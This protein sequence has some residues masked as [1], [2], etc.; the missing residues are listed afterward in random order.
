MRLRVLLLLVIN[1]VAIAALF[2]ML[3]MFGIV[4]YYSMVKD[5]FYQPK[6]RVDD[7]YAL[8]KEELNK[9]R[10]SFD[11]MQTDL[12]K[13]RK[14]LE[15]MEQELNTKEEKL[16]EENSKLD[17]KWESLSNEMVNI[18][19]RK[20]TVNDIANS[21]MN[22]PPQNSVAILKQHAKNGNDRLIIDVLLAIDKLSAE[23]GQASIKPYLLSLLPPDVSARISEK[24][25]SLSSDL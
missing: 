20:E 12:D 2:Y 18:K 17:L 14:E 16:Q 3:D 22:M 21:L 5:R 10:L 8:E 1:I 23:R 9:M 11:E 6:G 25:E 24:M 15:A 19:D 4:N 13:K 7:L